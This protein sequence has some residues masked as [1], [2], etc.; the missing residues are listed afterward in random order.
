M[1]VSDKRAA[2]SIRRAC[3]PVRW[4]SE[5]RAAWPKYSVHDSAGVVFGAT[6]I[7]DARKRG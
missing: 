4:P 1:M 7:Y 3:I 6:V 5:A 2:A